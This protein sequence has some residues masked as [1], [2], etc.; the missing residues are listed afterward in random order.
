MTTLNTTT[1]TLTTMTTKTIKCNNSKCRRVWNYQGSK[2]KG[3]KTRCPDCYR[4]VT[5]PLILM[6]AL[7]PLASVAIAEQQV[8]VSLPIDRPFSF[9]SC[10]L[11]VATDGPA[12]S[13]VW[14]WTLDPEILAL[15]EQRPINN[16]TAYDIWLEEVLPL[17]EANPLLTP[18]DETVDEGTD[19]DETVDEPL[20]Q[21]PEQKARA[22]AILELNQCLRGFERDPAL[23]A[24]QADSEIEF[25]ENV[26]RGQI[27]ERDNL[28]KNQPILKLLKAVEECSAIK[29]YLDMHIIGPEEANKAIADR[30]GLDIYGRP[31][32]GTRGN[33][34][35]L[36]FAESKTA[37]N[38]EII[39]EANTWRDWACAVEQRQ[40]KLCNAY[41]P[42]FGENRGGATE[43]LDCQLEGQPASSFGS[44]AVERCPMQEFNEYKQSD[45]TTG[46]IHNAIQEA[47]CDEYK[48]KYEYLA[49]DK[50]PAW[51]THCY[52][53]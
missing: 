23:G 16:Q 2:R 28:S 19:I 48:V 4:G 35:S 43:G 31:E 5:I 30:L 27:A 52:D 46:D 37:S 38:E 6:L 18:S 32:I 41:Q 36:G 47:V 9:D 14:S 25:Y 17:L 44:V 11:L 26:T 1:L 51:I 3:A 10:G 7:V 42:L 53:E 33:E 39:A 50:R 45:P 8:L 20:P 15:I 21:T 49:S 12:F 34:P 40:L 22:D 24:F 13:C 29:R